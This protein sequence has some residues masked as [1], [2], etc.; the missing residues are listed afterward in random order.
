MKLILLLKRPFIWLSRFRNRCGYGVHSPFAFSL[1]TDVF[2]EKR[3]YYCYEELKEK[4]SHIS[5][6]SQTDYIS[7]KTLKLIFRLT[8]RFQPENI[9]LF[10]FEQRIVDFIKRAK[11]KSNLL[12]IENVSNL[13]KDYSPDLVVINSHTSPREVYALFDKIANQSDPNMLIVINGICYNREMKRLWK[14]MIKDQR[15]GITFDLYDVGLIFFDK[16]KIK[17]DYIINF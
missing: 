9:L 17:Q 15:V 14:Q 10:T 8:N 13:D 4:H 1:I 16:K 2:Y 11:L 12:Y 6:S 5:M 3:Q 7:T